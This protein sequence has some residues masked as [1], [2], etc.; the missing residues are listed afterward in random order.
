M[1]WLA[2][3]SSAVQVHELILHW[4][5]QL[6]GKHPH[7]PFPWYL[8]LGSVKK[9]LEKLSLGR[10]N[11]MGA[12]GLALKVSCVCQLLGLFCEQYINLMEFL[13]E[14]SLWTA[15]VQLS[16]NRHVGRLSESHLDSS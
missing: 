10:K 8:Y 3:M 16:K 13:L 5:G 9:Q 15:L 11:G 14:I 7:L 12:I 2:S 6:Y 1:A 4:F